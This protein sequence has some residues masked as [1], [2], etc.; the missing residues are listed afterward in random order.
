MQEMLIHPPRTLMEVFKS[1]PE[2]TLAEVIHNQ[3]YMSPSPV[4]KHQRVLRNLFRSLDKFVVNNKLGEV[5]FSPYD[6]FLDEDANAVQPDLI[7]VL[8]ENLAIVNDDGAIHGVPDMLIEVLSQGNPDHDTVIKKNLYERFG[9][10]EYWIVDPATKVTWGYQ[11]TKD[12]YEQI[13]SEVGKLNSVLLGDSI[14]F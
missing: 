10:K 11:L 9:V 1:L 14:E 13:N 6:V 8:E 5:F 7:F 3:L 2:G 12:G 4:G